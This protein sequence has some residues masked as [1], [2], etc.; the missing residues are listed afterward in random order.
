MANVS[1]LLADLHA[2]Y[3]NLLRAALIAA[4]P[5]LPGPALD[6][7]GGAGLK[8]AWLAATL[9]SPSLTIGLDADRVAVTG[10][11]RPSLCAD[12]HALPLAAAS[13][14]RCW[15]VAA[16]ALF[17]DQP[18]ALAEA[19]RVLRPG[20]DLVLAVA[21]QRWARL[22]AWPAE[23]VE[24]FTVETQR[25]LPST[26]PWL[27]PIPPADGL[28]DDLAVLLDQVGFIDITLSANL[29]DAPEGDLLAAGLPLAD[30]AT[31]RAR[32]A[33]QLSAELLARCEAIEAE[34]EPEPV[35][36]LLV[37]RGVVA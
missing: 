25:N 12:A 15:C 30:W 7:A 28:G 16:L 4:S 31:L 21:G 10:A 1:P 36:L 9:S 22:R 11:P 23:L 33:P 18:A 26:M 35:E 17:A 2:P 29:L 34:A 32:L 19:R 13:L 6:L 3:N 27:R 5:P 24:L 20:G 8:R 14:G 37:A